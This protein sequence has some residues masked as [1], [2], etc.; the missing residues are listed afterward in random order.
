M[1]ASEKKAPKRVRLCEM[2][3]L[4]GC[5][6]LPGNSVSFPPI[7][8]AVADVIHTLVIEFVNVF[9]GQRVEDVLSG[10]A[11]HNDPQ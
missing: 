4:M 10:L 3:C 11:R 6:L 7:A 2:E 9:V 1:D 8:L 5:K